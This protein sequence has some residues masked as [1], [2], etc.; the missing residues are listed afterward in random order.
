MH[1]KAKACVD[2]ENAIFFDVPQN[3]KVT[4]DED[5][6]TQYATSMKCD[7]LIQELKKKG[8]LVACGDI[9]PKC[10]DS[11]PFQL[12]EK[13]ANQAIFG[14][15]PGSTVPKQVNKLMQL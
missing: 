15:K 3:F 6:K 4:I 12:Q 11:Q 7:S 14:W 10:Y 5:A 1:V 8:P 2:S 13:F 9:G